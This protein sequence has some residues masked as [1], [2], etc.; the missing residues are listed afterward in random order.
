MLHYITTYK[1]QFRCYGYV[2]CGMVYIIEITVMCGG[3]CI[4]GGFD[5]VPCWSMLKSLSGTLPKHPTHYMGN[6][7]RTIVLKYFLVPFNVDNT[8]ESYTTTIDSEHTESQGAAEP[9]APEHFFKL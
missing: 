3:A 1:L 2:V 4:L 8:H 6:Q 7:T 5:I 9:R